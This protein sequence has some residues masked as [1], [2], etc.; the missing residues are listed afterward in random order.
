MKLVQ[1]KRYLADCQGL[2]SDVERCAAEAAI[3]ADPG[4]WP[5]IP[6]AGGARKARAKAKGKGKR[7]GARIVYLWLLEVEETVYL[8]RAYG[9]GAQA[10]LSQDE[11]KLVREWTKQAKEGDL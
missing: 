2:L 9:K 3:A 5:V 4:R 1:T 7:G 6:A 10:D 8:L 11:K